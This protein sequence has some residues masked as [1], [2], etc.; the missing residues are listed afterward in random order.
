MNEPR[1][2]VS[3]RLIGGSP[4]HVSQRAGHLTQRRLRGN[5]LCRNSQAA[6]A[7]TR[8]HASAA[9]SRAAASDVDLLA[10]LPPHMG[11]LGLGRVQADLEA[12][13]G[14]KVD[15][16]PASDLEPAV[17]ARAERDLVAL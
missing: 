4:G 1:Q 7:E 11:L 13:L 12:I 15:L 9:L 3:N 2:Q 6:S 16:V 17:R 5:A 10:D 8:A 14:A